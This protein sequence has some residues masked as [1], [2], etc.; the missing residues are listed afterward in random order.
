GGNMTG[1]TFGIQEARRLE[2]LILVA[3]TI[4]QVYIVYNPEDQS[5]VQALETLGKAA[6]ALGVELITR[7]VYNPEQVMAAIESIPA[8]AD[9]VFILPDSLVSTRV[10]ELVEAATEL[11]LPTSGA[12]IEDVTTLGVLTSYGVEQMSSGKQAARLADQI[13]HGIKPA[14]LPVETAEFYLAINLKTAKTIGLDIP[15]EILLQA[16]IIIR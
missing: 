12:N 1:V 4:D 14:D 15:D 6:M 16:D 5:P 2:W 3:P 13:L 9:A 7:Q 8:E 10:S 11:E